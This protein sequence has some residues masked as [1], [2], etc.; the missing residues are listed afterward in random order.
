MPGGA[1]NPGGAESRGG[2]PGGAESPGGMGSPGGARTPKSDELIDDFRSLFC[3]I[4]AETGLLGSESDPSGTNPKSEVVVE[5]AGESDD[6]TASLCFAP[7]GSMTSN[8]IDSFPAMGDEGRDN[9]I[10]ILRSR[11]P[12]D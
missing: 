12:F 7:F 8:L 9:V 3:N 1:D 11:P 10:A 4:F 5:G 6:R 2:R